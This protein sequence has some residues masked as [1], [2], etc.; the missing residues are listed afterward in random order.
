MARGDQEVKQTESL[1]DSK[2]LEM[3]KETLS[4][5]P[6]QVSKPKTPQ[7]SRAAKNTRTIPV[8]EPQQTVT[9]TYVIKQDIVDA[10]DEL[11][12]DPATGRKIKGTKGIISKIVNNALI[13]ELVVMGMKD[14]SALSELE[15]Y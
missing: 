11:V 7:K 5:A 2:T 3:F 4:P 12:T 6:K 10:L 15:S 8:F 9:R 1:L 14:E 13:K